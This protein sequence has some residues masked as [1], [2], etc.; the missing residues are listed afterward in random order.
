MTWSMACIAKLKVMNSTIGRRPANAAPTPKPREA[1]LGDGRVHDALGAELLQEVARDLVGALVLG[2]LLAHHEDRVVAAHLLRHRVAQGVADGDVHH[3]GAFG[4]LRPGVAGL[5]VRGLRRP[6]RPLRAWCRPPLRPP[7]RWPRCGGRRCPFSDV[8]RVLGRLR[9]SRPRPRSSSLASSMSSA[10]SPSSRIT[11]IGSFTFTPSV[12][13][14]TS[15]RPS[16]PSSTASTSMVALSVS[17]SAI[18]SPELTLVPLLLEP[19]RQRALLHGR[20]QRGHQDGDRH[21][22]GTPDEAYQ[23]REE[24]SLRLPRRQGRATRGRRERVCDG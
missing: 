5:R 21:G 7:R 19:L 18:T 13:S 1:V 6:C 12:P 4:H 15:R 23:A 16:V 20:G 17:I 24:A 10:L 11:A 8:G 14:A 22:R 3:L 9:S 2:D